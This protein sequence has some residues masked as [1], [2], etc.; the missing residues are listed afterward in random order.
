MEHE[1]VNLFPT[2]VYCTIRDSNLNST[3]EKEIEDIIEEGMLP[4][5]ANSSSVNTHIFDTRLYNIKEFCEQHIKNYVDD[6]ISPKEEF[7]FYITQSWLNINKPGEEHHAHWHQNSII[8]GVFYISTIEDDSITFYDP[9]SKIKDIHQFEPLE[10]NLWNSRNPSINVPTNALILFP[11]WLNHSV[12]PNKTSDTNR[13]SIS[14]NTFAKGTFGKIGTL[15]ELM[16]FFP[17]LLDEM[18]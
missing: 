15:N 12:V 14:F 3:E 13:I 1:V 17:K 6:I 7:D 16:V 10:N 2:P 11:S 9:N 5:I 4:N 18:R 8:S